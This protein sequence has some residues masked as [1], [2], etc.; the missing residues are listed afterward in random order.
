[1]FS[2]GCVLHVVALRAFAPPR[3]EDASKIR[4]QILAAAP[5]ALEIGDREKAIQTAI[6]NIP[7]NLV[8]ASLIPKTSRQASMVSVS[9]E[10]R[11][12]EIFFPST[13]NLL[14]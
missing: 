10:P 4:S 5:D 13:S 8:T 1:M 12:F 2:A 6:A 11:Q 14:N 3:H 9:E 7:T